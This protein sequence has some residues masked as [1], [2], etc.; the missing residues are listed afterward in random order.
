[1]ASARSKKMK[2]SALRVL[3]AAAMV[4]GSLGALAVG[5][6]SAAD[7]LPA[8]DAYRFV[9]KIQVGV[10]GQGGSACTGALVAPRWVVTAKACF[11][12]TV[13]DGAPAQVTKA[14]IGWSNLS[15]VAG[16]QSVPVVRVVPHPDRDLVL[17]R[18]AVAVT[19]V[20]P[21]AV[22]TTAPADGDILTAAGFGRT[23]TD[24]VPD[25]P[26]LGTFTVGNAT[27]T[28]L[29]LT[30]TDSGQ[31]GPC[32]GDA[33][34][35]GLRESGGTVQLVAV[36][37]SADGQG[38]CLGADPAAA[39]GGTQTRVDDL[40]A[41][42]ARYLPEKSVSTITNANSGLCLAISAG[43]TETSARALQWTCQGGTEQ[44]WRL[45]KRPSGG[46]E[47]R[48]DHSNLCLAIGSGST[49][50]GAQ[51]LQWTCE[52]DTHLEQTWE[53][54]PGSSTGYYAL[55]NANSHLCLA[56]GG[57][58]T[59]AGQVAIQW[60]CQGGREQQW[61]LQARTV[62]ARVVNQYSKLC[63]SNN[64]VETN[65]A[66]MVQTTCND[67]NEAEWHLSARVGGYAQLVDDRSGLCLAIG[68]GS[69]ADKAPAIQWTCG[70]TTHAEQQWSVDVDSSGVT[71]LR[72][73]TSG[74]CLDIVDGSK[75]VGAEL[76]QLPCVAT[77]TGQAWLLT[78]N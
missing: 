49:T 52:G 68:G 40:G 18:L 33:G 27:S 46:Y 76:V 72:N 44:D 22:A 1:M 64:G 36:S 15:Q 48:N 55:R 57:G 5:P 21:V 13:T 16:G 74:K 38:G 30:G 29:S 23:A 8:S 66:H 61:K 14:L 63:M 43:S 7:A 77:D 6:T 59:T 25:T 65:A 58:S 4:A 28:V 73:K 24:W 75:T 47:I 67:A 53:L 9:A 34:G 39:H 11:G 20:A 42:F 26:H 71:R 51:A 3:S 56:M 12:P 54:V 31:V 37:H 32:K 10:P 35:P 19:D 41:W 62:G 2:L 50:T 45:A 69:T 78:D 17:A 70:D 60:T